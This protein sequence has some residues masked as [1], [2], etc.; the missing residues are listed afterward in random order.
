MRTFGEP[1]ADDDRPAAVRGCLPGAS[2]VACAQ[3]PEERADDVVVDRVLVGRER[4][5]VGVR[6]AV[7]V[8]VDVGVGVGHAEAACAVG[9]IGG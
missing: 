4:L 7:G 8:D 3:G 1:P 6:V 2:A 5:S 9:G